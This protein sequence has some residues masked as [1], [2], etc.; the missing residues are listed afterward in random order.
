MQY[1]KLKLSSKETKRNKSLR[2]LMIFNTNNIPNT[3]AMFE[4]NTM[5]VWHIFF[6]ANTT[7]KNDVVPSLAVNV[8][9]KSTAV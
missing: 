3:I 6:L 1:Q 4:T 7:C 2:P 8:W 9:L 5:K